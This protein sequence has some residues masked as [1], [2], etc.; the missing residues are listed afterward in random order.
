MRYP[1]MPLQRFEGGLSKRADANHLPEGV[2][3][4]VEAAFY[5]AYQ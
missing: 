2:K 4:E 1:K 5:K 3:V